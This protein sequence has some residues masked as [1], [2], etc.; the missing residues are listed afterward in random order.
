MNTRIQVEHPITEMITGVDIVKAQLHIA[1]GDSLPYQQKDVAIRGHAIECRI[2]AED[3][4]TF[5]P[6]P[7]NVTLFHAPGGPG[8]RVDSHLY[9]SYTVPPYYDS[10]IAK[11]ISYGETR[12]IALAK[13]RNALEEIIIEGI[14][15]NIP[16]QQQ[17]LNHPEFQKGGTHIHFLQKLIT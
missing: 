12:E 8:I 2:N 3:S 1:A 17:I 16:L 7:G 6:S 13:M 14:K 11:I 15:T 4:K 9:N 10:L 5:L